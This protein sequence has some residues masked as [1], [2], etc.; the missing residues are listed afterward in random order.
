MSGGEGVYS[1]RLWEH[2]GGGTGLAYTDSEYRHVIYV[3][4]TQGPGPA[5]AESLMLSKRPL[6]R[7]FQRQAPRVRV[8]GRSIYK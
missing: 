8:K 6:G 2:V 5:P 7:S 1:S 3:K 4:P